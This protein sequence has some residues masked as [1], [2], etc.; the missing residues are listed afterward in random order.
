[1][2]SA[3]CRRDIR[4]TFSMPAPPPRIEQ[5]SFG[6]GAMRALFTLLADRYAITIA[7]ARRHHYDA[8]RMPSPASRLWATKAPGSAPREGRLLHGAGALGARLLSA[9]EPPTPP[10]GR[11]ADG[12]RRVR[13]SRCAPSLRAPRRSRAV[14]ASPT[15]PSIF[16]RFSGPSAP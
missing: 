5:A 1:M 7:G 8:G 9:R 12:A 16:D 4:G 3:G 15:M 13:M 6:R 14:F 2:P 10:H 11:L